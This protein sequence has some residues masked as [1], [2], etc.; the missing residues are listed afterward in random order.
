MGVDIK[1]EFG[2]RRDI[3][4]MEIAATHDDDFL[5]A[6][7]GFGRQTE[8]LSNVGEW[9]YRTNGDAVRLGMGE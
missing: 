8:H 7:C 5:D 3:A 2:H 9:A 1:I 6:A 4:R